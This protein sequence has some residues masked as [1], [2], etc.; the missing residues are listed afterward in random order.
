VLLPF[1][2]G[3]THGYLYRLLSFVI[4]FAGL[5]SFLTWRFVVIVAIITLLLFVQYPISI[6]TIIIID[7]RDR[8]EALLIRLLPRDVAR[9]AVTA[10]QI[11]PMQESRRRK[12]GRA[13][14][15][16]RGIPDHLIVMTGGP[17]CPVGCLG[18]GIGGPLLIIVLFI[19]PAVL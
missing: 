14:D 17:S 15:L 10:Y 5:G 1:Q 11:D 13:T 19:N 6:S 9:R 7:C 12:A 3:L 8:N 18:K 2:I 4:E 16:F